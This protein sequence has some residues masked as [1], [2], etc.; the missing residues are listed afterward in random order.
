MINPEARIDPNYLKELSLQAAILYHKSGIPLSQAVYEV[1][2]N[3]DLTEE[4]LKRILRGA[5]VQAYLIAYNKAPKEY[6]VITFEGG[7]AKLEE[8]MNMLNESKESEIK[9]KGADDLSDYMRPPE[10]YKLPYILDK[11]HV[12]PVKVKQAKYPPEKLYFEVKAAIKKAEEKIAAAKAM[13]AEEADRFMGLLKQAILDGYS[14]GDISRAIG[15]PLSI[16]VL[17]KVASGLSHKFPTENVVA[18]SLKNVS[19][20]KVDPDN[21]LRRS[22]VKMAALRANLLQ[23]IRAKDYLEGKEKQILSIMEQRHAK[24]I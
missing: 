15:D 4:H 8:I 14:L 13:E 10:D 9:E 6:R 17:E 16:P 7:P 18:E 1:I 24:G 3:M 22:W 12:E 20:Q 23:S 2:R 11:I 19:Y 21:E 5:N